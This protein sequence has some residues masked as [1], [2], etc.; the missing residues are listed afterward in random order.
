MSNKYSLESQSAKD[1]L[2]K[3]RRKEGSN[4]Q[5]YILQQLLFWNIVV[6]HFSFSKPYKVFSFNVD[7]QSWRP[8]RETEV[9]GLSLLNCTSELG[10]V[11][12]VAI[13]TANIAGLQLIN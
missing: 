4:R 2:W 12:N 10:H 11:K 9:E 5:G 13:F 1:Q 8:L 3:I 7:N 6:S